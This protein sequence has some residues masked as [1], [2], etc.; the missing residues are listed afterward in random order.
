MA[1]AQVLFDPFKKQFHPPPLFVQFTNGQRRQIKIIAQEYKRP[2]G[3]RV[4]E[5]NSPQG[6]RMTEAQREEVIIRAEG[7]RGARPRKQINTTAKFGLIQQMTCDN[8]I[9]SAVGAKYL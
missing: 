7:S 1:N 5:A 3:Q 8:A 9:F 2:A 6:Q 4:S